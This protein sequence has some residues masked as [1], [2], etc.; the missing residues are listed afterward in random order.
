M[1][2]GYSVEVGDWWIADKR[3]E[4]QPHRVAAVTPMDYEY[5]PDYS[6][7]RYDFTKWQSVCGRV[8]GSVVLFSVPAGGHRADWCEVCF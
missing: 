6:M 2:P 3:G 5:P 7:P 8:Q 1:M 4:G